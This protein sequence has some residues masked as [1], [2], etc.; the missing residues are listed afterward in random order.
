M[1]GAVIL[2]YTEEQKREH[3]RELQACLYAISLFDERVPQVVPTG[4]YDS[5]TE[6]AVRAFQRAYGLP[7]TGETDSATWDRIIA[8]YCRYVCTA[9]APYH[10]FPSRG[11]TVKEGDSGELVSI[12]QAMLGE[13]A[14]LYDN[15]PAVRVSGEYGSSTSAAVSFFQGHCGLDESG[16]VDCLTWNMLVQFL[17]V[18]V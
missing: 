9:P 14:E 5:S 6:R 12:I 7:D 1:R 16:A 2:P 4:E 8:V 18:N 17:E 10:V 3:I 11:Y 13:A 15:M